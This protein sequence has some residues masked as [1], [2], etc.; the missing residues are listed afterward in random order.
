MLTNK[1]AG[2]RV[3]QGRQDNIL[4][5]IIPWEKLQTGSGTLYGLDVNTPVLS[6]T[7]LPS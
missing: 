2:S 5:L 7:E 4:L 3:S 1:A 6:D